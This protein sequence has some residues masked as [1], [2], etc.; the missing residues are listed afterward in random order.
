MKNKLIERV[1]PQDRSKSKYYAQPVNDGKVSQK[2]IASDIVDLSSLAR[3]DV[4]NVIES[5]LDTIPRYLIMGKSV[6][7]GDFGTL[8][9]SFSS[10]GVDDPKEFNTNMISGVK[11]IFTPSVEFK[12]SLKKVRFEKSV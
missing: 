10:K 11:V 4:A 9:L 6:N 3:G 2:A 5:L 8:R 7:L 1:N 12:T